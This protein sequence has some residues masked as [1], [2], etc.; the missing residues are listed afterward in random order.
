[1]MCISP[2]FSSQEAIDP[3][4]LKWLS[5]AIYFEAEGENVWG[6]I[7][8]AQVI[9]KRVESHWRNKRSV[10][11]VVLDPFQFSFTVT[12]NSVVPRP[13]NHIQR[14]ALEDSIWIASLILRGEITE[15]ITGGAQLYY[16]CDGT[17]RIDPPDWNWS[18]LEETVKI[19]NHCFFKYKNK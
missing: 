14:N 10:K 17:N 13:K 4:D 2:A 9:M 3:E 8:V 18:L 1:M 16:A 7:G 11:S 15:D 19:D 5:R 6:K 12:R